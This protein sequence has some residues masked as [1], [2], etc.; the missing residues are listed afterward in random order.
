MRLWPLK[1]LGQLPRQQLLGQHRE[2]CALRGNGWGRK[3]S[4]VDYV[5]KHP[6][7]WLYAY[8]H[9]VMRE[10]QKR[11][12]EIDIKWFNNLYRG[13]RL[14]ID[15]SLLTEPYEEI[16]FLRIYP[17]HNTKYLEECIANLAHKGIRIHR[18]K[19]A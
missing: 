11:G 14:G 12:Y 2:C 16:R 8:H 4:T 6:H 1:I 18:A 5:F 15:Y 7:W 9:E 19:V 13:K 3:H 10:M 17:E